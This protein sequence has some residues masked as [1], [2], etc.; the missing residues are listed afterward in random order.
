MAISS[1]I[2]KQI[3]HINQSL[4]KTSFQVDYNFV[5]SRNGIIVWE[6]FKD[7]SSA[8]KNLPYNDIYNECLKARAFNF[9]LIDGALIQ[10]MYSCKRDDILR[11]RLA[12]YPNPDV[13]R[14]QDNPEG[15]EE[16]HFGREL[17]TEVYEKKALIFPV[18]FDFDSDDKKYVEHNHSYSHLTL[19]NYENC[20]I[21]VSRPVSP[22]QFIV[23]ILKNFY[24]DRFNDYYDN[25]SFNC[26][27][28]FES[29]LS[30]EEKSRIHLSL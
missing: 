24:H 13:E 11:H 19:G 10:L 14:Y 25:K 4:I 18:R 21:P 12:F 7:I 23:F 16:A 1:K 27:L 6:G 15:F 17:F 2:G 28:Q 3:R 26:N 30:E 20:R 29:L 22:F 9:K 8:L 5:S